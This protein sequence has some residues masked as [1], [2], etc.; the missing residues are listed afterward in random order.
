MLDTG[1]RSEAEEESYRP[2]LPEL[3]PTLS[4]DA[5][6]RIRRQLRMQRKELLAGIV[7]LEAEAA[8]RGPDAPTGPTIG[9]LRGELEQTE[10]A[11]E[12]LASRTYGTCQVCGAPIPLHRLQVIPSAARCG[13]CTG[14]SPSGGPFVH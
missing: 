9:I 13:V 1:T 11:L 7:R 10:Q 3:V 14:S 2:H 4:A 5:L 12:R 8:G 6:R